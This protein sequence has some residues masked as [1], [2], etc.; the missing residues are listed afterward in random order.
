MFQ[1]LVTE[2]SANVTPTRINGILWG[3]LTNSS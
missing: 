1:I 3:I 2:D